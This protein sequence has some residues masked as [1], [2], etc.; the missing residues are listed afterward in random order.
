MNSFGERFRS[1]LT[2]LFSSKPNGAETFPSVRYFAV[3]GEL[4]E[5]YAGTTSVLFHRSNAIATEI[6]Q[7]VEILVFGHVR[8]YDKLNEVM[9]GDGR[10]G[11]DVKF[12]SM[13]NDLAVLENKKVPA[14]SFPAFSPL[15]AASTDEVIHGE[16]VAIRRFRKAEDGKNLQID[17]LRPDASIIVSDRRDAPVADHRKSR[18]IILCDQESQ[19]VLEFSSMNALRYYW[20]DYVIGHEQAVLFS[21]TLGMAGITHSYRRSNVAVIQ[22]FH[23]LHLRHDTIGA[24]GYTGAE[25]LPLLQH[26]DDF[27]A[28]VFLSERHLSDVNSLMGPSPKRRVIPN[29]RSTVSLPTDQ[30]RPRTTGIMLSQLNGRKQPDH[31]V[32]AV[33]IAN[34]RLSNSVSLDI[35][36]QGKE[37]ETLR[38]TIERLGASTVHLRGYDSKAAE[39]FVESSFSLLT[40]RSEALPL[41]LVESMASG[42]IPI[43]YDVRYG[44]RDIITDGVDGFLVPP[45]DTDALAD[46][47]VRLQT[48]ND[49]SIALMRENA[50]KRAQDFSDATVLKQWASL[51][52]DTL[53]AKVSPSPIKIAVNSSTH[54]CRDDE[55]TIRSEFTAQRELINLRGSITLLGRKDPAIIRVAGT[56]T[57]E[58][59]TRFSLT[60]RIGHDQIEWFTRGILDAN[61][62][63]YDQAGH[64]SVRLRSDCD[65]QTFGKFSAYPTAHGNLS[66]KR[67]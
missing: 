48:M 64:A 32:E 13:W 39:K 26:I 18:S 42:C 20:L 37:E 61:L 59:G 38:S 17:L 23:N 21:D 25:S 10:L 15:D 54:L 43:A 40:S 55:M 27:D 14:A 63:I 45:N 49:D 41:V 50:I 9:H 11:S 30:P 52:Q 7:P 3:M 60:T 8:D 29:S 2:K 44:P 62:D 31:A 51:I 67:S 6:R 28:T 58:G 5:N 36:G 22:T 16:G 12:R 1:S 46:T 4:A 34:S 24:L 56:L 57:P 33:V 65:A 19:P 35:Y 47:I 53:S 66:L